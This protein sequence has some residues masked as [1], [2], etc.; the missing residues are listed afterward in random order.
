MRPCG[1]F[2]ACALPLPPPP[3][4]CPPPRAR[5]PRRHCPPPLPMPGC[6]P[7]PPAGGPLRVARCTLPTTPCPLPAA[8]CCCLQESV[9]KHLDRHALCGENVIGYNCVRSI[10]LLIQA[11]CSASSKL[12][13]SEVLDH[14]DMQ[15][16]VMFSRAVAGLAGLRMAPATPFQRGACSVSCG[17]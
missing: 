12:Y 17:T 6:C 13:R 11:C 10:L 16:R 14:E 15:L 2:T 9:Q 4:L 8:T 1:S 5:C 7:R 3:K